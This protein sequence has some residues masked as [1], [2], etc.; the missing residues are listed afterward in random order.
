MRRDTRRNGCEIQ[1]SPPD[2][3]VPSR[4]RLR[5]TVG[6]AR[7]EASPLHRLAAVPLP[8]DRLRGNRGGF[9][10]LLRLVFFQ[11]EFAR[12]FRTC[13]VCAAND[14]AAVRDGG[15]GQIIDNKEQRI[16]AVS[17]RDGLN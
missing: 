13:F 15:G 5:V 7:T 16:I 11:P 4:G 3:S 1:N 10:R 2:C 9:A 14:P 17:L 12:I 6:A 8:Y